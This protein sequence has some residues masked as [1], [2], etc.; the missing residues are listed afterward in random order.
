VESFDLPCFAPYLV[1]SKTRFENF[2]ALI[3]ASTAAIRLAG[4]AAWYAPNRRLTA[5]AAAAPKNPR[6]VIASSAP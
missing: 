6:R 5:S 2:G 3:R 4:S 1:M